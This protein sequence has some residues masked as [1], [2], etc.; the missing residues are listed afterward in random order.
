MELREVALQDLDLSLGW[1]RELPESAVKGME[2]SLEMTVVLRDGLCPRDT[3]LLLKLWLSA[4]G[5]EAR[6]YLIE[7]SLDAIER[8]KK[9]REKSLDPRLGEGGRALLDGLS[10]LRET[11]VRLQRRVYKDGLG[12]LPMEGRRILVTARD[13][14]HEECISVLREIERILSEPREG[15]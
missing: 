8:A 2:S 5:P 11:S 4:P 14:A 6:R 3:G 1:L 12:E 7:H 10:I 15:Q 13:K 9:K